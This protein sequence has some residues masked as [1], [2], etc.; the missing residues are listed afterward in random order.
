MAQQCGLHLI[1]KLRADAALYVPYDGPYQG[2]GPRRKYGAKLDYEHLPAEYVQQTSVEGAIETRIY[3][4][5]VLHKEFAQ[6]LNVVIL[7][8]VNSEHA[9]ARVILFSSDL[10][11]SYDMVIDYYGFVTE[12]LKLLPEPP[13]EDLM[14]QLF[15][16]VAQLG[17]IHPASRNSPP[18][19]WRRY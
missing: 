11:M 1:S 8:K 19:N 4:A 3:Q 7:E 15:Y 17:R 6:P 2:R 10:T 16:Q 5:A 9:R 18:H 13:D 12:L 14:A